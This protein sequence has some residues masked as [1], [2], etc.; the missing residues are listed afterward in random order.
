MKGGGKGGTAGARE[1]E[2]LDRDTALDTEP[3]AGL[4]LESH[5]N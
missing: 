3:S 5:L 4:R 1:R 2:M